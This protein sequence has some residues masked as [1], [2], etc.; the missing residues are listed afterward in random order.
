MEDSHINKAVELID[1]A[2]DRI[3]E[4]RSRRI[5]DRSVQDLHE[6]V[7][8]INRN[9]ATAQDKGIFL[10]QK[11]LWFNHDTQLSELGNMKAIVD[12]LQEILKDK[13][14]QTELINNGFSLDKTFSSLQYSQELIKSLRSHVATHENLLARGLSGLPVPSK[15]LE[16]LET[17]FVSGELWKDKVIQSGKEVTNRVKSKKA[18]SERKAAALILAIAN[19]VNSA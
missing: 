5:G 16:S 6:D 7:A 17:K 15:H 3:I 1:T 9:I 11:A 18:S 2:C 14:V 12:K 4:L 10:G 13:G 8:I 19:T